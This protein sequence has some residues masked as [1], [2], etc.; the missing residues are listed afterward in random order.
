M[1]Q[2]K[3]LGRLC[4]VKVSST[5]AFVRPLALLDAKIRNPFIG[6]NGS[7]EAPEWAWIQLRV[8]KGFLE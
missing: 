8:A 4:G 7:Q 5:R 6:Y 1:A 3:R 2:I